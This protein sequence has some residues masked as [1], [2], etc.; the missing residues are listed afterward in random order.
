MQIFQFQLELTST[1][2]AMQDVEEVVLM[3]ITDQKMDDVSSVKEEEDVKSVLVTTE[4]SQHMG[5]V[6]KWKSSSFNAT[7][8]QFAKCISPDTFVCVYVFL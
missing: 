1:P 5:S 4:L 6:F 7:N 3:T 2:V 8:L